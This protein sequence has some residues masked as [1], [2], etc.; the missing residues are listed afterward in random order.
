VT[1][2]AAV[3]CTRD[4]HE[5]LRLALE[6]LREQTLARQR[7]EIVVVDN[8]DGSAVD[9]ATAAGSDVAIHVPEPGL[10]RARNAGS[11]V[12]TARVLAFLDDDAVAKRDWLEV[13]LDLLKR[14][15]AAVVGGPILPLYDG[16]PPGWFRDEY[17][18]RT[19]GDEER[20]LRPG[21]SFSASNLFLARTTLEAAGGF[22]TRLG[23]RSDAIAVGEETALFEQLW[24]SGH[25]RAAYSP[26]LVVHHRVPQRKTSVVYQ[27]RRSAAAGDAWAIRTGSGRRDLGRATRDLL[28]AVGLVAQAI[29]RLRRPWQQWAV[30]ELGPV[31]GRLGSLRRALQPAAV[32]ASG[33][34]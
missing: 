19:W 15:D 20:L 4:R 3:V 12:T 6:S 14:L 34:R 31:A 22:D 13:G 24:R 10:S 17:E 7:Y 32:A 28:A 25:I 26:R 16:R 21:E 27:L 8:G 2:L 30:E 1:D 11:A 33:G 5:L 18:L 9:V 23:M 29:P